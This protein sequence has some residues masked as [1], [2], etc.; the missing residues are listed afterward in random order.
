MPKLS[1]P[2][3]PALLTL[4]LLPLSL[5]AAPVF[6]EF[7]HQQRIPMLLIEPESGQIVTANPAA[8]QFYGYPKEALQ[9][10]Q[11]QQLNTLTEQQVAEEMERAL[12]EGRNHFIFR[13]RLADGEIRTVEVYSSPYSFAEQP[14]LLSII[15]DI[16]PGRS[17]DQQM[18]H[19]QERLEEMVDAQV[20]EIEKA[21]QRQQLMMYAA[22]LAQA[23]L[24][25][26]LIF[27]LLYRRRL[28]Q[29]RGRMV[30]QLQQHNAE[31]RRLGEVMAHHFQEPSRR[32][33]SFAQRLSKQPL[34]SAQA[35]Q[36]LGFIVEQARRL[37]LLI[38]DIER[39]LALD[40]LQQQAAPCDSQQAASKAVEQCALQAQVDID[41]PLPWVYFPPRQLRELF[42]ALLD[43]AAR[44]HDPQ[45]ALAIRIHAKRQ[46]ERIHFAVC[47]NGPGIAADYR[48]KVFELFA[49]LQGNRPQDTGTGVGLALLHKSVSLFDGKA[50][51]EDGPQGGI[52]VCF[53]L[54]ATLQTATDLELSGPSG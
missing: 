48:Q 39:Y 43:N 44:Y 11:I 45:R 40:H 24:I 13:H 32:L 8:S 14:L 9:Q 12:R 16:T 36:E 15:V 30:G 21:N 17:L 50:Y 7:F 35:Q 46:G 53:D 18:W 23:G 20:A 25:V 1:Y 33:S 38:R 37:S 51:I 2:T 22:L 49:R 10:R 41:A 34:D 27:A 54:P 52:C 47:D 6:D 42:V 31:L 3:V 4:L 5:Q 28:H 19:Y 29:L 26:V